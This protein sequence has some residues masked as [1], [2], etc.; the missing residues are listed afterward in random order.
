M[1]I[2]RSGRTIRLNRPGLSFGYFFRGGGNLSSVDKE[3]LACTVEGYKEQAFIS[4]NRQQAA[5]A[6]IDDGNEVQVLDIDSR[7]PF[8]IVLPVN[9][10]SIT[11]YDVNGNTVLSQRQPL[12]LTDSPKIENPQ[13]KT[14]QAQTFLG[15]SC[16]S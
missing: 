9:A 15:L 14:G 3:I 2:R 4:M 1:R 6:E 12:G 11:F 13:Q 7:K 8:V 10:G 16:F 5:R